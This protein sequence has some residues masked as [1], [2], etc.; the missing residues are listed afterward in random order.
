MDEAVL[1]IAFVKGVIDLYDVAFDGLELLLEEYRQV[2]F[3]DEADALGVLLV[4]GREVS[5]GG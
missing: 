5:L 3:A 4:G 1:G 2:Y